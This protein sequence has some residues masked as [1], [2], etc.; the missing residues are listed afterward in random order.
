MTKYNWLNNLFKHS[1]GGLNSTYPFSSSTTISPCQ[2]YYVPTW[3]IIFIQSK[4][5]HSVNYTFHSI[6]SNTNPLTKSSWL[7]NLFKHTLGGLNYTYPFS[8]STTI[9]PCQ[10]Y[11]IPTW[12]KLF[13]Y[14]YHFN[15]SRTIS[16]SQLYFSLNIF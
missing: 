3:H 1:L 8:S 6:Y 14:T 7:N 13:H 10:K 2:K 5:F 11:Y 9:S 16:F 15:S 4:L 12:F